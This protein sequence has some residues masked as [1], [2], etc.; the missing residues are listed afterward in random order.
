M[1]SFKSRCASQAFPPV[2]GTEGGGQEHGQGLVEYALILALVGVVAIATLILLGPAL[3]NVFSQINAGIEEGG[4]GSNSAS[5]HVVASVVNASGQGIQNVQVY[6]YTST[7][8][9]VGVGG[10]TDG[11]GQVSLDLSD[12]DYKFRADYRGR[13]FQQNPKSVKKWM[14]GWQSCAGGTAPRPQPSLRSKFLNRHPAKR[15]Q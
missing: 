4:A 8:R 9:Y 12:G 10:Q 2:G 5:D 15:S 13:L 7:G 3:G 14:N 11:G 1:Q 6:A